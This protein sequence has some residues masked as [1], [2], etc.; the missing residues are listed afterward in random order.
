MA[1]RAPAPTQA[2]VAG[3]LEVRLAA[4]ATAISRKADIT[5]EPVYSSVLLIAP[6]GATWRLAVSDTGVLSTASV[7][8]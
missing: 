4:L 3:S 6:N 2:P 8:R 5:A 1:Y 7:P